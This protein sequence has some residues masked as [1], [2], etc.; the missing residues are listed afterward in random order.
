MKPIRV[1]KCV[2]TERLMLPVSKCDK[3]VEMGV[4]FSLMALLTDVLLNAD[5]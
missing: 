2:C 5:L 4:V 3:R 1:E